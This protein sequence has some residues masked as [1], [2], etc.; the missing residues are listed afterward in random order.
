MLSILAR[1]F[2]NETA[3]LIRRGLY[4]E[5]VER[6]ENLTLF[7]GRLSVLADIRENL[8]LRHRAVCRYSELTADVRL[9]QFLWFATSIL[10]RLTLHSSSLQHQLAWNQ[11]HLAGVTPTYVAPRELEM[12]TYGRLNAHYRPAISLAQLIIENLV[13]RLE[14][15][16]RRGPGFLLDMDRVYQ[17][18]LTRVISDAAA[19]FG[20]RLGSTKGLHLDLAQR[21]AIDPD[22]VLVDGQGAIRI[23]IDAK[24][25]RHDP[26]SDVYQALAYAKGLGLRVVAL[27]YPEDGEVA[28]MV[29]EIRNDQTVVLV[30]TIP[31]G[32]GAAA[33]RDLDRRT[34]DAAR[35]IVG[36]LLEVGRRTLAA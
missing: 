34:E 3:A 17:E 28:P 18:F 4:R 2:A 1:L 12:V 27:V 11:L 31:V 22:V 29:H 16:A 8:G 13:Y 26:T 25:K 36:E 5:Y 30:R 35:L 10:G 9:N 32:R 14:G 33:F 19:G 15:G 20:L 24:Y 7:K 23:A 21:V 6:E